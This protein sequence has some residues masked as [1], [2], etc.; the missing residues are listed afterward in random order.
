MFDQ[1][2]EFIQQMSYECRQTLEYNYL[3]KKRKN[4]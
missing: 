2:I 4:E 3:N 1:M